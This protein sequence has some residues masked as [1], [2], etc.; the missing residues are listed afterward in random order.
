MADSTLKVKD[1]AEYALKLINHIDSDGNIDEETDAKYLN[2]A[3]AYLTVLQ[4]EVAEKINQEDIEPL[5]SL[6][7]VISLDDETAIKTLPFGLAMYFAL[8]ERDGELYNHFNSC[9]YN[10]VLCSLKNDEATIEEVYLSS[11]DPMMSS[12]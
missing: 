11:D 12:I 8:M 10:Q 9:F 6:D 5:T 4:L 3:P 1:I 2:V 7:D